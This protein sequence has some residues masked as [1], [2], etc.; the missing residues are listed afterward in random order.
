M[1]RFVIILIGLF[2][3]VFAGCSSQP[4]RPTVEVQTIK[5]RPSDSLLRPCVITPERPL[6]VTRDL[7][8]NWEIA[9]ADRDRCAARVRALIDWFAED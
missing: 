2:P 4:L 6:V 7:L 9:K 5:E 8:I 3:L 1:Q